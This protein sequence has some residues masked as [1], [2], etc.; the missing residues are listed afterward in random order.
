LLH[1]GAERG[2][3]RPREHRANYAG[4]ASFVGG[5]PKKKPLIAVP[6]FT[7]ARCSARYHLDTKFLKVSSIHEHWDLLHGMADVLS[8]E[9]K[10]RSCGS[11]IS[12]DSAISADYD[13][14]NIDGIEDSDEIIAR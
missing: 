8:C 7:S 4:F 10:H 3:V 1:A 2:Y 14:G 9:G 13:N 6:E 5:Y 11:I 12:S